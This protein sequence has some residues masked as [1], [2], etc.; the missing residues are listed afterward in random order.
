MVDLGEMS[1]YNI[2]ANLDGAHLTHAQ[3]LLS[4]F[5][6]R[7]RA[8]FQHGCFSSYLKLFDSNFHLYKNVVAYLENFSNPYVPKSCQF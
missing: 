7:G 6:C 3:P 8:P 2:G 5:E 4:E 1:R